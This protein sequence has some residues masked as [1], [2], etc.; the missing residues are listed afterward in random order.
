MAMVRRE[1]KLTTKTS[2]AREVL[3]TKRAKDVLTD[4]PTRFKG[5]YIFINSLGGPNLDADV[6]NKYWRQTLID[7]GV[8]YR[9]GYNCRNT[10]ASLGLTAGAKTGFLCQQL[11]HTLKMFFITYAKYIKSEDDELELAKIDI[12]KNWTGIR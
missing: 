11:G 2:T 9:R 1:V 10:Y 4:C 5:G 3:L 12:Y 8:R 7:A 6:F